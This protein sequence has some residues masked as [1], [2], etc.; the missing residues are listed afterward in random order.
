MV[1]IPLELVIFED[2]I[3]ANEENFEANQ[4]K[5]LGEQLRSNNGENVLTDRISS[6]DA[7]LS[8]L[9]KES[10]RLGKE[11]DELQARINKLETEKKKTNNSE[12]RNAQS[13]YEAARNRYNTAHVNY[14]AE[15]RK[16]YP[17]QRSLNTYRS[18]MNSAS[19]IRQPQKKTERL[20]HR[21]GE[22]ISRMK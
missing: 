18:Q 3:H 20:P 21:Y 6:A 8:R 13:R 10:E 1:S 16:E 12:Y 4:V 2:Y 9:G 14:N 17:S 22:R 11:A 19:S 15:N 7:T 5:V